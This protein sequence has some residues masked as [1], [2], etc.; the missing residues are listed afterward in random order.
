[1][2]HKTRSARRGESAIKE[3]REEAAVRQAAR[4]ARS[5]ERQLARLPEG[6][7]RKERAKLEKR[8]A[9]AQKQRQ[10]RKKKSAEKKEGE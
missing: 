3:R 4:G 7:A 5:D 1:M 10:E 9:L 6:G 2:G 8:I